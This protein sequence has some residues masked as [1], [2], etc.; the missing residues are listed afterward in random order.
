MTPDVSQFAAAG[1]SM[2]PNMGAVVSFLP[3]NPPADKK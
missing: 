1:S 3:I 2:Q